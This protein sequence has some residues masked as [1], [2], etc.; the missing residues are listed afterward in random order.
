MRSTSIS[1]FFLL[2][3]LY[4]STRLPCGG[5]IPTDWQARHRSLIAAFSSSLEGDWSQLPAQYEYMWRYISY[6]LLEAALEEDLLRLLSNPRYLVTKVL[7][8]GHESLVADRSALLSL[9]S[10]PVPGTSLHQVWQVAKALT[11]RV[12]LLHGL[13]KSSDIAATLLARLMRSGLETPVVG[14]LRSMVEGSPSA[15]CPVWA[16]YATGDMSESISVGHV[17]A[18]TDVAW[19][20]STALVSCGEDGTVRIWDT[21]LQGRNHC[22]VLYGH[23]GWVFAVTLSPDGAL[24]ASAGEDATVRLWDRSSGRPVVGLVGHSRRIRSLQ[25]DSTGRFLVSG[26]E[27]GKVCVWDVERQELL[28]ELRTSGTPVW[29][30]SISS[31]DQMVAVAGE[32]EFVRLFDLNS[33]A[34]LAERAAHRDWVRSVFFSRQSQSPLLASGSG[35]HT[36]RLWATGGRRLDPIRST[37]T[38]ASKVRA[39]RFTSQF[40]I[41]AADED[42]TLHLWNEAGLVS[43]RRMPEGVDWVRAIEAT[44][45]GSCVAAACEDGGVRVWRPHDD[46]LLDIGQG[47]NAIWSTAFGDRGRLALLGRGDGSLEVRDTT[48]GDFLGTLTAGRG[49][50]WSLTSAGTTAAAACGDGAIRIWDLEH[51]SEVDCVTVPERRIWSVAMDPACNFLAGSMASGVLRVWDLPSRRPVLADP[52]AHGGRIRSMAFTESGQSLVTGSGDG[53]VRVWDLQS[54]QVQDEFSHP[55]GWVRSVAIDKQGRIAIGSGG[56]DIYLRD[57][58]RKAFIAQFVGHTGRV[59]ML[60]FV[61]DADQLVSAAADGTIRVWS[62][63]DGSQMSEMRCDASLLCASYDPGRRMIL[64]SSALETCAVTVGERTIAG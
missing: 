60:A 6:H 59:L 3:P 53:T 5:N 16:A 54:S 1:A 63:L 32:D 41:L 58:E 33:G 21:K 35:D 29:S 38:D 34:L 37:T 7:R 27:D 4:P 45:D 26:A 51:M 24:I 55:G 52:R 20:E 30:V 46:Q 42:A 64:A 61:Q 50:V 13:T 9:Q 57:L 49:R 11:D 22:Q 8:F 40:D 10:I 23:T 12:D 28:R 31:D 62:L 2:Q 47:A 14:E 56:G 18:V 43:R 44:A 17:G 48:S 39:V 19:G 15:L 36:V 25:F